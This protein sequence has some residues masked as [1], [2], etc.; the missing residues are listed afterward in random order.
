[1]GLPPTIWKEQRIIDAFDVDPLG[2][3]RPQ[4]L[5]AYLLN[6]AWNHARGTSYGHEELAAQG[7]M[8]VLIKMEMRIRRAPEWREKIVVE[9][10]GKKRVKLYALRDFTITSETGEKLVSATSAWTILDR[11]SGRPHRSVRK[12]DNPPWL[13]GRDEL[14]TSFGKVPEP[15]GGSELG[16]FRVLFSDI[17]VNRHVNSSRY[18]QW[19]IDG[20]P[21]EHLE[22]TYPGS[23]ELSFL[24]EAG[25]DDEVLVLSKDSENWELCSVRRARDGKELCRGRFEWRR[26]I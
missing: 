7:L 1:M 19:M 24:S 11:T 5:F 17:D 16:R 18:L 22:T 4:M 12:P 8:W 23:I 20:H 26:P 10:W 2:R 6:A 9:T 21:H 13:P 3:L 15:K 14:E 25:P